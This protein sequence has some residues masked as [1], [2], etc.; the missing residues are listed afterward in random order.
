MDDTK[1]AQLNNG[2]YVR[3]HI[4]EGWRLQNAIAKVLR[5]KFPPKKSARLKRLR[6]KADARNLKRQVRRDEGARIRAERKPWQE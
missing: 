3:P 4:L 1:Y 5:E 6:R 2:A